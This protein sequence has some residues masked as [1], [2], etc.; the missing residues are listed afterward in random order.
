MKIPPNENDYYEEAVKGIVSRIVSAGGTQ[1]EAEAKGNE[2]RNAVD[3]LADA[4]ADEQVKRGG[5]RAGARPAARA[6]LRCIEYAATDGVS[7][8]DA[9]K[10]SVDEKYKAICS[11]TD[12]AERIVN[13]FSAGMDRRFEYVE[14]A[15]K[16]HEQKLKERMDRL[17]A[18]VRRF[19]DIERGEFETPEAREAHALF[20]ALLREAKAEGV[21]PDKAAEVASYTTWAAVTKAPP[22]AP[23]FTVECEERGRR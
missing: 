16:R 11:R 22:T 14:N 18:S 13:E 4:F 8:I 2:V 21:T 6:V 10:D 23:G 20:M 1:E 3:K 15:V 17:E 7:L 12:S 5:T 19:E 9:Y